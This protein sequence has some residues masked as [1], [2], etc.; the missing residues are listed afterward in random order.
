MWLLFVSGTSKEHSVRKQ[1]PMISWITDSQR[2]AR[3]FPEALVASMEALMSTLVGPRAH[4][5][6]APESVC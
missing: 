1:A 3:K 2:D 5:L 6:N 4:D